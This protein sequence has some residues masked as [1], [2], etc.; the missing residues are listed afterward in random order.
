MEDINDKNSE[1]TLV[2]YTI[3]KK[4]QVI[5]E[6]VALDKSILIKNDGECFYI[7]DFNTE[8]GYGDLYHNKGKKN[9][10]IDEEVKRIVGGGSLASLSLNGYGW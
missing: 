4:P 8:K 2:R 9:E 6:D 1:G 3:G 5:D 10:Q 7:K